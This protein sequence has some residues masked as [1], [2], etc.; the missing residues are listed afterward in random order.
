MPQVPERQWAQVFE[1]NGAALQFRQVPVPVPGPAELLVN[2]KYSGVCHSDLQAWKGG[3]PLACKKRLIGGHEGVGIVVATGEGVKEIGVGDHWINSICGSC[4][5]CI[6]GDQRSCTNPQFSGYTKDGTFQEYAVCKESCAVRI[7]REAP[8]DTIAPILCAGVTVYRA[9]KET[10]AQPGQI[11]AIAGAGGGLGTL[12]C[13]YA[14]AL[15]FRVLAL[16]SGDGKRRHCANLGVDYF[17]DYKTSKNLPHEIQGLTDGG[18]HAVVVVSSDDRPIHQAIEYVRARGTIVLV[19]LPPGAVIRADLFSVIFRMITIKGSYVG[20]REDT[21]EAL[22]FFVRNDMAMHCQIME[23]EQLP[24]V[25][26]LMEQANIK[27]R[28][29]LKMP[30]SAQQSGLFESPSSVPSLITPNFSPKEHNIGTFLAYRL[31]ELGIKEFFAVPGDSNLKLIDQLLKNQSLRLVGCCNELNAG[32]AADGYAR[33]SPMKVA[34]V[35]VT[36]TV[37]GLSLLNAIAG[38]CSERLRVIVISGCPST[39]LLAAGNP[40]HHTTGELDTDQGLRIFQEF[41]ATSIRLSHDGD[42]RS[43]LDDALLQCLRRS[44]PIYIEVPT[45]LVEIV[46]TPVTPLQIVSPPVPIRSGP[47]DEILSLLTRTWT[48]AYHPVLIIGAFARR[49]LSQ[50]ALTALVARLG[51]AVFCQ[52][53]AKSSLPESH[54]Q[55]AGIFWATAS[56]PECRQ[57]VMESDLWVVIGGRWSDLHTVGGLDII[58]ERRRIVDIQEGSIRMPNGWMVQDLGLAELLGAFIESSVPSK[59]ESLLTFQRKSYQQTRIGSPDI[60]A[61]LTVRGIMDGIQRLLRSNDTLIADAGDSWFNATGILLPTGADFQIQLVYASLGWSLP[62][63]IGCQLARPEGRTILMIGDG[64]FQMTAQE[65][66]TAIR[67]R[68]NLIIFVFNNLGYQIESAIHDGPYNYVASW[69]YAQLASAMCAPKHIRTCNNP[70]ATKLERDLGLNPA[71]FSMQIK[72]QS[73]LLS[74][75][76]RA[77]SEPWKLALL[78]CCI[79]PDDVSAGLRQLALTLSKAS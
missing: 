43:R 64:A 69:S 39:K 33:S 75:L 42:V 46:G 49:F 16:S 70:F 8:L 21:E 7:P 54:P 74:A 26:D 53:D 9:L 10:G 44:L 65:L 50:E 13:Q 11:I 35:V 37:G 29:V 56:T 63:A 55:F 20:T 58:E 71:M 77:N 34:V 14:K 76:D 45:D 62:A 19:G 59:T 5:S 23:L 72:T 24:Q 68:A 47:T 48:T 31:E 32:Y 18:P 52:P 38:A 78:E 25:Y 67:S 61:A 57:T 1:T 60:G 51:C 73:D 79:Q 4:V 30:G 12:A 22:E 27:G 41:T 17:V 15:G 2:I 28:I 3:W 6:S 66:S 36:Y 40:L